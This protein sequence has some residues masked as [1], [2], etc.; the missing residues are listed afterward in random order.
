MR[1]SRTISGSFPA[2]RFIALSRPVD[3][4]LDLHSADGD[5]GRMLLKAAANAFEQPFFD[6]ADGRRHGHGGMG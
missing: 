5:T 6:P 3:A 4:G 2:G 1:H